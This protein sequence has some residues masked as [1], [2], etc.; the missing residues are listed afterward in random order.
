MIVFLVIHDQ[1]SAH[2]ILED[3][4]RERT[5]H[6]TISY[7]A[8]C[9]SMGIFAY[10]AT[11]SESHRAIVEVM[12][13]S[14]RIWET[15]SRRI[16]FLLRFPGRCLKRWGNNVKRSIL[17]GRTY[18][19]T[20]ELSS[21]N[22]ELSERFSSYLQRINEELSR[23]LGSRVSL[24]EDIGYHA[25]SG[26]GKRL[27]PLLF[28]LSSQ[29]CGY[30]GEDIWRFSTVFEYIHATSLAHDDVLDHAGIRRN[31]PSLNR[32]WG[33]PAAI[34][35]GDFFF[36]KA[37]SIA[38]ESKNVKILNTLIEAGSW[39]V[40][41]QIQ[42]LAHTRDWGLTKD[43]Y[44]EI[45]TDK[46]ASLISAACA[47]GAILSGVEDKAVDC[48][49]QFGLNVGIAFQLTDDL[50]DY[51]A[52]EKELGKPGG[53]DLREGKITLPLIYTLLNLA[54]VE[55]MRLED[56]FK[57]DRAGDEDYR[58]LIT[59]IKD[60]GVIGRIKDE[61]KAYAQHAARCLDIFPASSGK[62]NL[63]ELNAHLAE[64][65]Q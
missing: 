8:D 14:A 18:R 39:M 57:S 58:K 54:V 6:V 11:R 5:E 1:V 35:G 17:E 31:K 43:K 59:L 19:N 44:M 13:M 46:T 25:I 10:K 26:K 40:E 65:R 37:F 55:R 2:V 28:V 21:D 4:G 12:D 41:G 63:L 51:T 27:R 3:H 60:N 53:T 30:Q 47:S 29:L 20:M 52:C 38:V 45:I 42:E 32:V 9:Q 24:L 36:L 33:N 49:R 56:L 61:A 7:A 23:P 16:W 34:L 62:E 48:L 15:R 22:R 64:R 50:L